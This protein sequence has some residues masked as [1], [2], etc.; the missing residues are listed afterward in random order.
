G[1]LGTFRVDVPR[2]WSGR[3][4]ADR[5]DGIQPLRRRTDHL[6]DD[7]RGSHH[8]NLPAHA[9]EPTDRAAGHV[10]HRS[11]D[12]VARIRSVPHSRWTGR[13]GDLARGPR[14]RAEIRADRAPGAV[15]GEELLR[16]AA[17]E[18]EVG[19]ELET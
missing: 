10:R 7:G 16:R 15:A 11:I 13:R 18:A 4:D 1:S 14:V 6:S 3:R 8:T 17:H 5:V 9:D 12:R 19:G 2:G